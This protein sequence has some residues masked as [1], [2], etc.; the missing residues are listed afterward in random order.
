MSERELVFS[1]TKKDFRVEWFSGKGAGGQHRNK[2]QNCCRLIH[3]ESGLSQTGQESRER[4][5]NLR[6]AFRRLAPRLVAH[7][8]SEDKRERYAS[9]E[10]IRTYHEPD[11]RVKDYASGLVL[12]YKQTVGRGDLSR[13]IDARRLA[14]GDQKSG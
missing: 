12:P 3:I 11:N 5:A 6:A 4:S 8:V 7:Y 10:T 14:M 9:T 1:A 13:L 2:H